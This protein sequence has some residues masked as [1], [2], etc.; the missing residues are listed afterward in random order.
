M[1]N[2]YIKVIV[3]ILIYLS[4]DSSVIPHFVYR[5]FLCSIEFSV[6]GSVPTVCIGCPYKTVYT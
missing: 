4:C 2:Y 1:N 5:V 6:Y 3:N